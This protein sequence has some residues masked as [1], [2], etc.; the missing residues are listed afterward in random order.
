MDSKE[1]KDV[2]GFMMLDDSTWRISEKSMILIN[3]TYL[4]S[5]GGETS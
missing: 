2:S 1:W 4:H 5:A 3:D